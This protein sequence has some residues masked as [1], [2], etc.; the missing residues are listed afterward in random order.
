MR[1][2]I[3]AALDKRRTAHKDEE[4]F[5]LSHTCDIDIAVTYIVDIPMRLFKTMRSVQF[6]FLV[7]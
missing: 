5:T 4:L 2:D 6:V 7:S 1:V 3:R